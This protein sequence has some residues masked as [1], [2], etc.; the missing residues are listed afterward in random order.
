MN[1]NEFVESLASEAPPRELSTPLKALWYDSNGDWVA[2]HEAVQDDE[3]RA[4][5]QVHAYLHRKEGDLWNARYWYRVAGR[6]PVSG[7]LE[8]ERTLMIK[9]LLESR[10]TSVARRNTGAALR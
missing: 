1:F 6:R 7:P 8:E 9:E 3:D 2:A 4:S 10:V 5:A